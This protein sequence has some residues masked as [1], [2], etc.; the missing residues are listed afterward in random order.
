VRGL[1]PTTRWQPNQIVVLHNQ[2][3]NCIAR[4]E[5]PISLDIQWLKSTTSNGLA[6][7][8]AVGSSLALGTINDTLELATSCPVNNGIIGGGLQLI[9]FNSPAT[10]TVQS[11]LV[12][13]LPSVTWL[14]RSIPPDAQTRLYQLVNTETSTI[15]QCGGVPRQG[16]YPFTK[17]SPG[18]TVYFDE[19]IMKIKPDTPKGLYTVSVGVKRA[20]GSLLSAVDG[21]GAA[22]DSGFI[23]VG[24]L[25]IQ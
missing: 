12:Y 22:I 15:L 6:S 5:P 4:R 17:W 24:T 25:Q 11:Q 14:A 9:K 2:I 16:T 10:V 20:D 18:E 21:S 13:Y 7:T 8:Q 1:Y 19:C 23:P 3:P